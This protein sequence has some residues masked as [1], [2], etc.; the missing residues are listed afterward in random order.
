MINRYSSIALI[1]SIL[2]IVT[3]VSLTPP[4][5]IAM[6]R[7]I[8]QT[9]A[10]AIA[11]DNAIANPSSI[12]PAGL[13]FTPGNASTHTLAQAP[14]ILDFASQVTHGSNV[15]AI[16][17]SND[18][19]Y[20][21][22]TGGDRFIRIWNVNSVLV[23]DQDSLVPVAIA[24]PE[25]DG[26]VTSMA[27]SPDDRYLV[28]GTFKGNVRI[29]DLQ[30]C[31]PDPEI[32]FCTSELWLDRDYQGVAPVVRFSADG[33]L[34]AASNYDG[35]VVL[36]DWIGR[37]VLTV[38]EAETG[39][40]D[41]KELH[42]RFSSLSFSPD[43]QFLAAGSHDTT[44]TVWEM[45]DFD[46]VGVIETGHGV[47]SVA[48]SPDGKWLANGNLYGVELRSLRV[49]RGR[50]KVDDEMQ[51]EGQGRV[52]ALTFGPSG[53]RLFGGDNHNHV[54]AWD[55]EEEEMLTAVPPQHQHDRP[56]LSVTFS[57]NRSLMAS[58]ST[59]G[60]IKLWQAY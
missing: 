23:G 50:L 40:H 27:F 49:S 28:T 26:Y 36:W 16:G 52:N 5:A 12:L 58:S 21:A 38:L 25:S 30:N 32:H 33:R 15:N 10:P 3:A 24:V 35:T 1:P 6:E 60:I 22:S 57:P 7:T 14:P 41:G 19:Q 54:L 8:N 42:G 59:D 29:W 47:D 4:A 45:E 48:F 46:R 51:M 34:L 56:V 20:M 55:L 37:Q 43:G 11:S 31:N 13:S 18:G 39:A 53:K 9:H 17:F 2:S 44:I